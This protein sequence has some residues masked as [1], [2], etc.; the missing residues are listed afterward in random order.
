MKQPGALQSALGLD[1]VWIRCA[2]HVFDEET[3]EKADLIF[4]DK[5]NAYCA[6]PGTTCFV[7]ELKSDQA[8]H[9][10]VGQLQKAVD[11]IG[12]IG[13]RI[14]HWDE[15]KGIAIAKQYTAS[16]LRL[17]L[18]SGFR[19]FMWSESEGSVNLKELKRRK[20]RVA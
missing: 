11:V 14:G 7:V 3:Q 12:E 20:R 2:E 16:G 15:T 17:L 6:E 10:V 19:A 4:Q 9:E 5:Y 18:D 1:H 8:D 13:P